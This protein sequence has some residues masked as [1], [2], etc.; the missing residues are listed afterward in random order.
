MKTARKVFLIALVALALISLCACNDGEGSTEPSTY[1]IQYADD[2]G[3]HTIDVTS[4]QLYSIDS[5]P[6]RNG[7][8][9]MGLYDSEQGGTQY[10]NA[11]GS[12][13]AVFTDNRSLVLYP[14]FRAKQ[15]TLILDYQGADVTGS[16]SITVD[17][18]SNISNL[19]TNLMME[20]KTFSGWFTSPDKKGTQIADCFGVLPQKSKVTESN[21][22]LSD[23]DGYIYLYAGFTGEMHTVRFYFGDNLN[24]E[25]IKVEHG[26]VITDVETTTR[27]DGRVVVSW[28]KFK[29]GTE[30]FLGKIESDTVLYA[31]EYAPVIEFNS[32]GGNSVKPIIAKAGSSITLP[33]P[34]KENYR[35]AGWYTSGGSKYISTLMGTESISLTARWNPM[36]IFNTNGGTEVENISVEVGSRITLPTT[37]KDGW[38]FVGWY[39]EQGQKYTDTFM[40]AISIKL[41]ARYWKPETKIITASRFNC[42]DN[43]GYN[44]KQQAGEADDRNRHNGFDILKLSISN[45]EYTYD[46]SFKIPYTSTPKLSFEV[47]CNLNALPIKNEGDTRTKQLNCDSYKGSVFGTNISNRQIGYGAYYIKINYTDGSNREIN[48]VNFLEGKS[49]GY[50]FNIDLPIENGK[51]IQTVDIVFVYEIRTRGPGVLG[52]W[53]DEATNWRNEASLKFI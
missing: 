3:L 42:V 10:V 35:F 46:G 48:A 45:I 34:A 18:D 2:A 49:K 37:S 16:R 36:I 13:L 44:P 40:P 33:I 27:V 39:T 26:T 38:V 23:P 9:F 50:V 53:W 29:N 21:F 32:N 6:T 19:P 12:A 30:V 11:S 15:F 4:G 43:N 7:Y 47:M 1:T 24:P 52:I 14:Q 25:E 5:I 41:T 22:D 17:Y 28:T 31:Y 8:E 20:N 51:K